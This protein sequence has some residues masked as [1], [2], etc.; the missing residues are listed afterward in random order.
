MLWEQNHL[1]LRVAFLQVGQHRFANPVPSR[2]STPPC[3]LS[4]A[5]IGHVNK[6]SSGFQSC[7]GV[8]VARAALVGMGGSGGK[9]RP[10]QSGTPLKRRS[11]GTRERLPVLCSSRCFVVIYFPFAAT[12]MLAMVRA[13]SSG[14][15]GKLLMEGMF[16]RMAN[17]ASLRDGA[18]LLWKCSW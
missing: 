15:I 17:G 5:Q 3:F 2:S 10:L 1:R 8:Q 6:V 4:L 14:R 12:T 13:V 16:W 9:G 18:R 11:L 7:G